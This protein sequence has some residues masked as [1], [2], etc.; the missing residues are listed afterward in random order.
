MAHP[1][2]GRATERKLVRRLLVRPD[3]GVTPRLP[4][5]VLESGSSGG[6]T[7]LLGQLAT[8]WAGKLPCSYVDVAAVERELGERA[9]PQLLAAI[10]AQLARRSGRYGSLRF[11]RLV[12]GLEVMRLDLGDVDPAT[13]RGKI[14]TLL[15]RRRD[16]GT[17]KRVLGDVAQEVLNLVPSPVPAPASLT[18]ALVGAGVDSLGGRLLSRDATG[19]ARAWWGHQDQDD[20]LDPVARLT[21]LNWAR[22]NPT[23]AQPDAQVD[24]PLCAAF[25]AD[26]RDDFRPGGRRDEYPMHCLLL[27]DNADCALGRTFLDHLVAARE[28]VDGADLPEAPLVVVAASTGVLLDGLV[29]TERERVVDVAQVRDVTPGAPARWAR[30]VLPALTEVDLASMADGRLDNYHRANPVAGL[31]LM[32]AGHPGALAVL[33]KAVEARRPADVEPETLLSLDDGAVE[34]DL[35]DRLLPDVTNEDLEVLVTCSAA[36][37]R[38]EGLRRFRQLV[39]AKAVPPRAL[40]AP[41]THRTLIRALLLRRLAARGEDHPWSRNAAHAALVSAPRAP[42]GPKR[43]ADLHHMLAMGW[44]VDVVNELVFALKAVPLAEWLAIAQ[45][46]VTAPRKDLSDQTCGSFLE[47]LVLRWQKV[48]DPLVEGDAR[49]ALHD[50]VAAGLIEVANHV[51]DTCVELLDLVAYH[52]NEARRWRRPINRHH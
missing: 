28:P 12:I 15:D 6:R 30:R 44:F 48:S 20:A 49:S 8:G 45:V 42:I 50:R 43:G 1:L 38:A 37:D 2:F 27:L 5:L 40:W 47:P 46:V 14:E 52:Q 9:V 10:A 17:L 34:A 35:V 24:A 7:A 39:G 3:D 4:V 19:R 36:R 16:L 31:H 13:Q 18:G 21:D 33:L 11:D 29:P 41:G 25:V 26:L 32:T 23:L 22:T 51:D